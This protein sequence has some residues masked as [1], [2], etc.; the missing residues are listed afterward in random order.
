MKRKMKNAIIMKI[1]QL[2]EFKK[3]AEAGLEQLQNSLDE[4]KN[5]LK[6]EN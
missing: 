5:M 3:N 6:A 4:L 2:E 1:Q